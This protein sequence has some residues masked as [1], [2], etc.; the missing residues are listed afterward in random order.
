MATKRLE[1]AGFDVNKIDLTEN[2]EKLAELKLARNSEFLQVPL[3]EIDGEIHD[4][5]GLSGIIARATV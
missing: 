3:F 2:P 5:T 1:G 4:I